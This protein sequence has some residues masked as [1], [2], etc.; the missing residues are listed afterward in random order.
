MYGSR[1]RLRSRSRAVALVGL[2]GA[3]G[4]FAERERPSPVEPS[5]EARLSVQLLAPRP[6]MAVLTGDT[7]R[8]QVLA[9]DLSGQGLLGIG[10]LARR[11]S[12]GLPRVDSAAVRFAARAD[13][14]H[15]FLFIMPELPTNTQ[16]D[17]YGIAFGS[18]TQHR[19]SPPSYVI[20][21]R[22]SGTS[23]P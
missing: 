8:V 7:V 22:C 23:C 10:F 4:C 19:V 3:A 13:T 9:R 20:A 6:G 15:E 14:T 1:R 12:P 5:V 21:V 18:G 2:I 16:V 11:F 17:I